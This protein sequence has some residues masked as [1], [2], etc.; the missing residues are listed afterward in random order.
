MVCSKDTP[1]KWSDVYAISQRIDA[2]AVTLSTPNYARLVDV[3]D[4]PFKFPD[5]VDFTGAIQFAVTPETTT[6]IQQHLTDGVQ[7]LAPHIL[8]PVLYAMGTLNDLFLTVIEDSCWCTTIFKIDTNPGVPR[9][10]EADQTGCCQSLFVPQPEDDLDYGQ[11][12]IPAAYAATYAADGNPQQGELWQIHP[13]CV[14]ETVESGFKFETEDA[15]SPLTNCTREIQ[16]AKFTW[17][18]RKRYKAKMIEALRYIVACENNGGAIKDS[19]LT[20]ESGDNAYVQED[21]EVTICA[22]VR[23]RVERGIMNYFTPGCVAEGCQS[24]ISPLSEPDEYPWDTPTC[25]GSNCSENGPL[26]YCRTLEDLTAILTIA[27]TGIKPYESG[28][29]GCCCP[30]GVDYDVETFIVDVCGCTNGP[31]TPDGEAQLCKKVEI[32]EL[33]TKDLGGGFIDYISCFT[34]CTS[35]SVGIVPQGQSCDDV[36]DDDIDCRNSAI[37][38]G[39]VGMTGSVTTEDCVSPPPTC[40]ELYDEALARSG[41]SGGIASASCGSITKGYYRITLGEAPEGHN[42]PAGSSSITSKYK[43]IKRAG[44]VELDDREEETTLTWSAADNAYVSNWIQYP[45]GIIKSD[46]ETHGYVYWAIEPELV[47][48]PSCYIL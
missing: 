11:H 12:I 27:E 29:T 41:D 40:S 9:V 33:Y 24:T 14:A 3:P 46:V 4:M 30:A 31:P 21:C 13:A 37:A 22:L 45:E 19:I 42:C 36:T 35:S 48:C 38:N 26:F 8:D 25:G 44:L 23:D 5:L 10:K 7:L 28:K 39:Y 47:S 17:P 43:M 6:V 2:L 20:G 18:M 32:E 34:T 16:E 1:I 15:E